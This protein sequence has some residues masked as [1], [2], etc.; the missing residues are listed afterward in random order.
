METLEEKIYVGEI[1]KVFKFNFK[2]TNTKGILDISGATVVNI[3]F[4]KEAGDK[5]TKQ[6]IFFTDGKDGSACY[7]TES[8]FL[9]TSGY[10]RA[11]GFVYLPEGQFFSTLVRFEVEEPLWA[12]M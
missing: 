2:D 6:G 4:E 8:G 7:V 10:W 3:T 11:Q 1:G 5:V 12:L 9:D